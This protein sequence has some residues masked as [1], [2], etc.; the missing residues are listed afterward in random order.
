MYFFCELNFDMLWKFRFI[1]SFQSRN[2]IFSK[3]VH[4]F[5]RQKSKF[6]F[7]RYFFLKCI[8]TSDSFALFYFI[9]VR[10]IGTIFF[11]AMTVF[12][13]EY[14]GEGI[15]IFNSFVFASFNCKGIQ[16]QFLQKDLVC[17]IFININV[18]DKSCKI[19]LDETLAVLECNLCQLSNVISKF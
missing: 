16:F 8:W 14:L 5:S 19:Y 1:F 3:Y 2:F 13:V 10:L 7:Y 12:I 15:T 9:L 6:A 18:K 17:F 4:I 11:I